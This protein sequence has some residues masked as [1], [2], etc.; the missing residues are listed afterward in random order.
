M[1]CS[2]NQF[3]TMQFNSKF[4][5]AISHPSLLLQCSA[6]VESRR[7]L[8]EMQAGWKHLS[9]N[10]FF[11]RWSSRSSIIVIFLIFV[12]AFAV[13]GRV[14][15]LM[16]LLLR[17]S[18]PNLRWMETLFDLQEKKTLQKH[19]L[20][21]IQSSCRAFPWKQPTNQIGFFHPADLY[22][23]HRHSGSD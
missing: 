21:N 4:F 20:A 1:H 10:R 6:A 11:T 22:S 13:M 12:T 9:N 15:I 5:N 2:A 7:L 19:F 14:N 8:E 3:T 23:R 18:F 17:Q 16:I